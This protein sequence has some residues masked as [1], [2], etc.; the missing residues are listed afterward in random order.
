MYT[1]CTVSLYIYVHSRIQNMVTIFSIGEKPTFFDKHLALSLK[2]LTSRCPTGHVFSPLVSSLLWYS[3]SS[4]I[5]PHSCPAV[6]CASTPT[7]GIAAN[8]GSASS[9]IGTAGSQTV[10]SSLCWVQ[11]YCK[12]EQG[13]PSSAA[14]PNTG[15]EIDVCPR[16]ERF[17]WK[18]A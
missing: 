10:E 17:T 8:D 14:F 13:L 15:I 18:A 7:S 9:G 5:L 11:Q 6:R 2:R 16:N 12:A 1:Q 3:V 4:N